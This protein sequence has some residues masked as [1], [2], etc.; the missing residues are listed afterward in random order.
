MFCGS[1]CSTTVNEE[2]SRKSIKLVCKYEQLVRKILLAHVFFIVTHISECQLAHI[3]SRYSS[4]QDMS[5]SVFVYF[6][7][8]SVSVLVLMCCEMT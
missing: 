1:Q 5:V 7:P 2:N 4:E 8:L 3:N 6:S